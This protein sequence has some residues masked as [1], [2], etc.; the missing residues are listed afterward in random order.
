MQLNFDFVAEA[1]YG[2]ELGGE[3][4]PESWSAAR[5]L[6]IYIS[7]TGTAGPGLSWPVLFLYISLMRTMMALR[8]GN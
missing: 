8:V 4:N 3:F 1:S 2:L 7:R 6:L 5:T